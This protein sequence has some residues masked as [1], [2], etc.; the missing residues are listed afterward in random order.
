MKKSLF[1]RLKDKTA[2]GRKAH[3]NGSFDFDKVSERL[4]RY[5]TTEPEKQRV[6]R[7]EDFDAAGDTYYAVVSARYKVAQRISLTLFILFV[8]LAVMFNIKSI[9]FDNLF[10]L[11]KDLGAAADAGNTN[12][13][14]LAYDA[15][16]DQ[17]FELYR[18]G[19][20]V[21][22]RTNV[23]SFTST[24]RRTLNTSADY[25]NPIAVSNEKYLFVYDMGDS[26]FDVYNSFAKIH[27]ER[28]DYPIYD[29]AFAENGSFVTLSR[30]EEFMSVLTVY[31]ESFNKLAAYKKDLYC[32][33]VSIDKNGERL[34]A[35]YVGSD[36]G[37]VS[38]HVVFYDLRKQIKIDEYVYSGEFPLGCSF[39]DGG[40][41]VMVSDSS[42]VVYDRRLEEKYISESYADRSV[43]GIYCDGEYV[44]V[45]VNDGVIVD[46]N[47][48]I[49]F[50]KSG[51]LIYDEM[52]L[53]GVSELSVHGGYLFVKNGDG[54][55]RVGLKNGATELLESKGGKM[56]VY[57][58]STVI[59]CLPSKAVYLDFNN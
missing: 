18:G 39:L 43:S 6:L 49:V 31:T 10:Y 40:G 15:A 11:V 35:V 53:S 1:D 19:L 41:F 24:G 44:A 22:S 52:L 8:L 13:E 48:I 37:I 34:G 51:E 25:S 59:V 47:E 46:L 20:A 56:F 26:G 42:A 45:A 33:D 5:F 57:D 30:S 36:D 16:S 28:T 55:M 2:K 12:Y 29:M 14:S 4:S 7:H 9:T 23:S 38:T 17:S 54:V 21:V 58:T 3:E 50:N 32:I 27:S